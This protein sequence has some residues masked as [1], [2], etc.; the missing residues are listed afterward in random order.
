MIKVNNLIIKINNVKLME[1]NKMIPRTLMWLES[2]KE[3]E[4]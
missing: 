2:R 4:Q 3:E 1:I